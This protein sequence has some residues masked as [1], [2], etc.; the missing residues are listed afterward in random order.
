MKPLATSFLLVATIAACVSAPA[1]QP[2][3][4]DA[5][6]PTWVDEPFRHPRC[7]QALCGVGGA[8]GMDEEARRL[9]L[10]R[11]MDDIIGSILVDVSSTIDIDTR[12][13][14]END[15]VFWSEEI[16]EQV[17]LTMGEELPGVTTLERW[18]DP[19]RGETYTL[20]AVDR[21]IMLDQYL[22]PVLQ[23]VHQSRAL[24]DDA[25]ARETTDPGQAIRNTLQAY[26]ALSSAYGDAVKARVVAARSVL[27]P[28]AQQ[29]HAETSQLLADVS[30]RL[31][32]LSGSIR[33]QKVSGD[34]QRGVVG[35]ALAQPLVAR[36]LHRGAG[37]TTSPLPDFPVRFAPAVPGAASAAASSTTT[38]GA[39][40]A[41]CVVSALG[42][43]GRGSNEIVVQPHYRLFAPSLAAARVPSETFTYWLPTPSQTEVRVAIEETFDGAALRNPFLAEAAADH[44]SA[45]GF[46]ARTTGDAGRTWRELSSLSTDQLRAVL[47]TDEGYAILGSA[48]VWPKGL[49]QGIE[50]FAADAQLRIV[51]LGSG[52][53]RSASTSVKGGARSATEAG[54]RRVMRRELLPA[55][56]A[57]IDGAFVASFVPLALSD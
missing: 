30:S 32:R 47:G 41:S 39:G 54:A 36:L 35:G 8:K 56:L 1:D 31:A 15:E 28:R 19:D 23:A 52:K 17:R 6:R 49:E 24:L 40:S 34:G 13:R 46:D 21:S 48:D 44:L 2:R 38:D 20:A 33:I 53:V 18:T 11:A 16:G 26:E 42:P 7:A 43:T 57:E 12:T 22:P 5:G 45:Y 3:P 14:R 25:D 37:G 4:I 50:W 10:T 29:A 55:L 27:E 51:H 9:S